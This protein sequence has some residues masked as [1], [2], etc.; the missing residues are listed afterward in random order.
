MYNIRLSEI[1]K[2]D[3]MLLRVFEKL[4]IDNHKLRNKVIHDN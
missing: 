4:E 2:W 3:E 1:P